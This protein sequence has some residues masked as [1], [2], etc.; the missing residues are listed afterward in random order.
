MKQR[1]VMIIGIK[2]FVPMV[3][4]IAEAGG[5]TALTAGEQS[6]L[7]GKL[8]TLTALIRSDAVYMIGGTLR[9]NRFLRSVRLLRRPLVIHWVGSDLLYA[10][11]SLAR[12]EASPWLM[13][14]PTHLAEVSWS[15]RE[16]SELGL[17]NKVVPLTSAQLPPQIAPLPER[18]SVVTYLPKERPEFYGESLVVRAAKEFPE[19]MFLVVARDQIEGVAVPPNIQCIGYVSDMQRVYEQVSALV[20]LTE[21]DGLSFMVLEALAAGRHVLWTQQFD[22]VRYTMDYDGLRRHL[23]ELRDLHFAG[24]LGPNFA[25]ADLVQRSYSVSVV[26]RAL[27]IA[28]DGAVKR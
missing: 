20:R 25:G 4:K 22:S 15:S 27:G 6:G 12:G 16:L 21:H 3:A 5:W 10:R 1:T 11:Q 18:L 19:I 23:A 7:S 8:K 26:G 28:L 2:K 13:T 17:N 9:M 24:Q 14:E